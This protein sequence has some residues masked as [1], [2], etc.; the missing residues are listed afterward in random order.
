MRSGPVTNK[1]YTFSSYKTQLGVLGVFDLKGD[2]LICKGDGSYDNPYVI[3]ENYEL[4]S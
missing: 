2:C 3:V 1:G 4:N